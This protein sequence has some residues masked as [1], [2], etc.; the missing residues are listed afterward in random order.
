M[1]HTRM[2]IITIVICLILERERDAAEV[3]KATNDVL[4]A[5]RLQRFF[6]C[7]ITDTASNVSQSDFLLSHLLTIILTVTYNNEMCADKS[8][9]KSPA[10]AP[11][12]LY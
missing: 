8:S 7:L 2:E 11:V 5:A 6:V 12:C 10:L 4:R 3:M 1:P 9:T